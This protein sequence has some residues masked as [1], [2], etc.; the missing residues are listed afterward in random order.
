MSEEER[1]T[2]NERKT[3]SARM[4]GFYFIL[5]AFFAP[6]F[7]LMSWILTELPVFAVWGMLWSSGYSVGL[8]GWYLDIYSPFFVIGQSIMQTY[9]RPVFAYQM[10]RF[11]QG[12]SDMKQTL[13][14]GLF[15]ELQAIIVDVP[16]SL[17]FHQAF[18]QFHIP[19]PLLLIAAIIT[20]R[21][22]PAPSRS[23]SWIEKEQERSKW[24]SSERVERER[25]RSSELR[26]RFFGG[27]TPNK[28]FETIFT[29]EV[30]LLIL[31]GMIVSILDLDY[32]RGYYGQAMP[33]FILIAGLLFLMTRPISNTD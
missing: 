32:Y 7:V 10:V 9:L 23:K 13:L 18:Y 29:A 2:P 33:Q 12:K 20:V 4:I 25:S 26:T 16:M 24:W 17:I 8:G 28:V 11:Y 1:T 15:I 3:M 31:G 19:I 14:V 21:Y 5:I 27:V 6:A 30:I 22:W